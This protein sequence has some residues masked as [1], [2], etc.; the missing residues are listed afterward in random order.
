[1][2]GPNPSVPS[3]AALRGATG[4]VKAGF[5][6]ERGG[7]EQTVC[8]LPAAGFQQKEGGQ[9]AHICFPLLPLPV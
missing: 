2:T 1:M 9:P 7:A 8:F 6:K 5:C 3:P 4:G